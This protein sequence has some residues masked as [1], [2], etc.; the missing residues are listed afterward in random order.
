[1]LLPL[2]HHLI[3]EGLCAD[4]II[5][6]VIGQRLVHLKPGN[7]E[8]HHN[9]GRRMPLRKHVLNLQAGVV[10]PFRHAGCPHGLFHLRRQSL[11][12]SNRLHGLEGHRG[13]LS[14]SDE[15]D[16]DIIAASDAGCQ[17]TGSLGNQV[18]GI[19]QPHICSV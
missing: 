2:C 19:S 11:S 13:V 7:A 12:L 17:R 3:V 10:I 5:G 6:A 1:M 8:R 15:I 4:R 16:H 9:V 14:L 18:R